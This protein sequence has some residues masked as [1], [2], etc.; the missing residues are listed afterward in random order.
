[1]AT[2]QLTV[3]TTPAAVVTEEQES[4]RRAA[5]RRCSRGSRIGPG[6]QL[7][8]RN[9]LAGFSVGTPLAALAHG[10]GVYLAPAPVRP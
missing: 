4:G 10:L 6:E 5:R 9:P 1:M 3:E 2:A 8:L 7:K